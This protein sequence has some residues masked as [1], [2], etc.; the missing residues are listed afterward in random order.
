M[1]YTWRMI[2]HMDGCIV[3][4][5]TSAVLCYWFLCITC[6]LLSMYLCCVCNQEVNQIGELMVFMGQRG[7]EQLL[8]LS[9]YFS[10]ESIPQLGLPHG[11]INSFPSS[12]GVSWALLLKRGNEQKDEQRDH[13]QSS[14]IGVS[15]NDRLFPRQ[16]GKLGEESLEEIVSFFQWIVAGRR[17]DLFLIAPVPA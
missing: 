1:W 14:F 8:F 3:K 17:P 7:G 15:F 6:W 2:L 12:A 4:R 11:F 5:C 10:C 13:K 16:H 9:S